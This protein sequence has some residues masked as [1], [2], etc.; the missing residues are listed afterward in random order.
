VQKQASVDNTIYDRLGERWYT[1]QDDP[2]ALL[3]AESKIKTPWI[4]QKIENRFG[5]KKNLRILDIGCGAGFLSNPLAVAGHEVTGIDLAED[6]L[7]I[8]KKYDTTG[9]ATYLT[10]DALHLPW[11]ESQ[12]DIVT[13]MD[14]LEHVD[15]PFAVVK[16]AARVLRPGG[17]FFFHTFNR[18][19]LSH[20]VIIKLVEWLVK[21]TP[22]NMHV[23]HLFI[24]PEELRKFCEHCGLAVTEMTG[25]RP[26]FSTITW[27]AL[28]NR[29]VP[30]NFRFVLTKSLALSYLGCSQKSEGIRP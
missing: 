5:L 27:Q 19:F 18:N 24:K 13:A 3:R 26:Q 15:D 20:L 29:S 4:L 8:A 6:A 11:G 2:V 12:F 30:L 10:A 22:K 14:F 16:E 23:H 25:I 17:L 1:A 28:K 21:N 9:R 7:A